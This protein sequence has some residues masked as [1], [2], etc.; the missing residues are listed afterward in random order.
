[1]MAKQKSHGSD[2]QCS[3]YHFFNASFAVFTQMGR[4]SLQSSNWTEGD[5]AALH[6]PYKAAFEALNRELANA[7]QN[8]S[9]KCILLKQLTSS[10]GVSEEVRLRFAIFGG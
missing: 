9:S 5:R 3:S 1:M 10:S 7:E 6:E 4:G 2:V 8:V